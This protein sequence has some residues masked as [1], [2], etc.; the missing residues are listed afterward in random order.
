M[1]DRHCNCIYYKHNENV[2]GHCLKH[3]EKIE[4]FYEN[5]CIDYIPHPE[6]VIAY[7][8]MSWANR[9]NSSVWEKYSKITIDFCEKQEWM[10][11]E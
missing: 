11:A 1:T 2:S 6:L 7:Y 4:H 5:H 8:L 9:F 3:D 10:K